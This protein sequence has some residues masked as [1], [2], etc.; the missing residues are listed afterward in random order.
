MKLGVIG[1]VISENQSDHGQQKSAMR[2]FSQ[3]KILGMPGFATSL[4][5]YIVTSLHHFSLI[6]SLH[7]HNQSIKEIPYEH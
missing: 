7:L 3:L 4:L 6:K 5:R 1:S 2:F